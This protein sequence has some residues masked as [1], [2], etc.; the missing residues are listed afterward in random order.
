M[1]S[2]RGSAFG[3][4]QGGPENEKLRR[5]AL[6]QQKGFKGAKSPSD[7]VPGVE[8]H[9]PKSQSVPHVVERFLGQIPA[10]DNAVRSET[11]FF[12]ECL[13]SFCEHLQSTRIVM[14]QGR[15]KDQEVPWP[16]QAS[17]NLP[18]RML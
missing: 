5:L 3:P 17:A 13:G 12:L 6:A 9:P 7:P 11:K 8:P 1:G 14:I 18:Q 4:A 15:I 16:S 2:C 10:V